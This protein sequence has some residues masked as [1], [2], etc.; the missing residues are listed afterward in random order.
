MVKCHD[1]H[2]DIVAAIL[3]VDACRSWRPLRCIADCCCAVVISTC[4]GIS[5]CDGARAFNCQLTVQPFLSFLSKKWISISEV[6]N[7]K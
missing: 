7:T 4:F 6:Q 2:I 5:L 3:V 1:V